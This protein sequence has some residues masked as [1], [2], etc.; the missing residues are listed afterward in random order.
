MVTEND[1]PYPRGGHY[2]GQETRQDKSGNLLLP[3]MRGLALQGEGSP[4]LSALRAPARASRM[5][6]ASTASSRCTRS[7]R[8]AGVSGGSAFEISDRES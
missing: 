7:A 1:T 6:P 5:S 4:Y 8:S 2:R 3:E